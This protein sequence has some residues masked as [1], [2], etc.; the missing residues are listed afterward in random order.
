MQNKRYDGYKSYQ[1]LE[2]GV[3][4]KAFKL[5]RELDRVP[6]TG[7]EVSDDVLTALASEVSAALRPY[8]NE[9]GLGVPIAAHLVVGHSAENAVSKH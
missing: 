8:V 7:V 4:Y 5:A 6:S 3:D 9:Q 2:A 1:Y